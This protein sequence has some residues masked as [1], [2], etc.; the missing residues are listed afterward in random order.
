VKIGVPQP[1]TL[2]AAM[3]TAVCVVAAGDVWC[4]GDPGDAGTD[5]QGNTVRGNLFLHDPPYLLPGTSTCSDCAN[6]PTKI[7]G[8]ST[9]TVADVQL[10]EDA[11]LVPAGRVFYGDGTVWVWGGAGQ[12]VSPTV[13]PS[14]QGVT[15]GAFANNSAINDML[16]L[17]TCSLNADSRLICSGTIEFTFCSGPLSPS[18]KFV[19]VTGAGCFLGQGQVHCI[20]TV[21]PGYGQRGTGSYDTNKITEMGGS[22]GT[23]AVIKLV[24]DVP[25]VVGPPLPVMAYDGGAPPDGGLDAPTD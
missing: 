23:L 22:S 3:S 9:G 20:V 17:D 2:M 10:F 19:A 24:D 13:V 14:L 25:V 16:G 5:G 6:G 21:A 11:D 1:I 15:P 12:A 4:W 7:R 8:L 18:T